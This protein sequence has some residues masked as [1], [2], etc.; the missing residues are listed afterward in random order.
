MQHQ[1]S[2]ATQPAAP[3]RL[4]RQHY[5][6]PAVVTTAGKLLENPLHY[7]VELVMKSKRNATDEYVRSTA[8]FMMVRGRPSFS[9]VRI[10]VASYLVGVEE[11]DIGWGKA[12]YGGPAT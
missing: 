8:D 7:A 1:Y 12:A 10:L 5:S 9:A 11:V 2:E 3:R 6:F 4:L